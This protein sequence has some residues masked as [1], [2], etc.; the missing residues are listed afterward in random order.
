MRLGPYEIVALL[1]AGG[2]GAVYRATDTELNREVAIKVLPDALAN[3]PDY[4]ARFTREAQVLASLNQPNIAIIHGVEEQA[5]VME[6]VRGQTLEER[7]A[8]GPVPLEETLDIARQIA[9]A[10]EAA[11]EKRRD[12]SRSQARE[13]E[14]HA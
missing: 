2:M 9:V 14:S 11:H 10:L 13:R 4:L 5:L 3:D 8:A 7:I 1:G 12:P 6:L